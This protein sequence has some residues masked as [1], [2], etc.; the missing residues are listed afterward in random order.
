VSAA[1]PG[2]GL[3]TI[4]GIDGSGKSVL[5][6]RLVAALG[7]EALVL[8]VDDFRRPV[9]WSGSDRPELDL[10]WDERYDF[11]ALGACVSAFLAGGAGCQVPGFDGAAET[12]GP[13]RVVSFADKRWLIVEGVFVGRLAEARA[14]YS[15]FVD[16]SR[17]EAYRRVLARDVSR[18]RQEAEVRRR[19]EQRYFPAHERYLALYR[20]LD[21]AWLVLDNPPSAAP[22]VIRARAATPGDGWAPVDEA[23]ARLA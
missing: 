20:P 6:R 11:A 9:D 13:A 4:D 1:A 3:I 12:A 21:W 18:G 5:A 19:I 8:A 7:D 10:Y 17:D 22:Q 14:G 2:R 16:V 23:L 15:V